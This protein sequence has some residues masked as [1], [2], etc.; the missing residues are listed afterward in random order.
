MD[1]QSS[2]AILQILNLIA[3]A[4]GFRS[5]KEEDLLDSLI[6]QHQLQA[7]TISWQDKLENPTNISEVAALVSKEHRPL[8]MKTACMVAG[9]S[10]LNNVDQFICIEEDALL[11]ELAESFQ[12]SSGEQEALRA[13]A[14]QQLEKNPSLWQVLFSCFGNQFQWPT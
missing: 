10:R 1:A 12:L 3:L 8:A 6:K 4:D 7:K 9:V 13:Q 14:I 2:G 11:N 5:P